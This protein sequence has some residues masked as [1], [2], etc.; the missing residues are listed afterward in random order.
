MAVPEMVS[1]L[2]YDDTETAAYLAP[3][4]TSVHVPW[5]D[6]TINGLNR[7]CNLCY[8]TGHRVR[9]DFPLSITHRA[10]LARAP[11]RKTP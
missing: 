11:A 6:A 5:S 3:P 8:G 2:G 10:S 1:V 4:L 9:R 7:L